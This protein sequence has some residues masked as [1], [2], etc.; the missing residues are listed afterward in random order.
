MEDQFL[1]F[2]I[3]VLYVLIWG[4]LFLNFFYYMKKYLGKRRARG[5]FPFLILFVGCMGSQPGENLPSEISSPEAPGLQ[6]SPGFPSTAEGLGQALGSGHPV[7][8]EFNAS[9]CYN[10]REQ[11]KVLE[12]LKKDHPQVIF[13]SF[14]VDLDPEVAD[15]YGVEYIPTVIVFDMNGEQVRTFIGLTSKPVLEELLDSL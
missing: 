10:C 2:V 1:D 14:D 13:L 3:E 7:V 12:E 9:W 11:R 5:L 8:V 4:I 15:M 6:T